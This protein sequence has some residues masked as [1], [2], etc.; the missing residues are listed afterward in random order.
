M[1]T[2]KVI[3]YSYIDDNGDLIEFLPIKDTINTF[4]SDLRY[5]KVVNGVLMVVGAPFSALK[6]VDYELYNLGCSNPIFLLDFISELEEELGIDANKIFI[7]M[8]PGDVKK[9]YASTSRFN[10]AYGYFA[11]TNIHDGVRE[12]TRWFKQYMNN[13]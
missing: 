8:Q 7:P 1:K 6:K 12:F 9:T 13:Q 10:L 5:Q 3:K 11:R 4:T 2:I